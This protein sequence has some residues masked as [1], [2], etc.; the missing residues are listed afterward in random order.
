MTD[1]TYFSNL[2]PRQQ[3]N[4]LMHKYAQANGLP[5]GESWRELEIRFQ[6]RHRIRISF[7]KWSYCQDHQLKMTMPAFLETTNRIDQA[8]AIAHDMINNNMRGQANEQ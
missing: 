1:M 3:L 2:T 4:D 6:E 5:Y 8:L 7:M